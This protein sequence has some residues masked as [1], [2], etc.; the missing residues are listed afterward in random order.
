[1]VASESKKRLA[2]AIIDFLTNST[3]D[4][5]L[6]SDETESIEVATQCIADAFKV[7]PTDKAAISDAL[8]GQTLVSIYSVFEKMKGK[9]ASKPTS[10]PATSTTEGPS[11]DKKAEA[12]ALKSKGNAAIA[13]KDF[14]AAIEFYTQALNIVPNHAIYLSNRAAAYSELGQYDQAIKDAEIAVD[15]DP[16]Y[17]K[18]WS[19]LGHARYCL[20]DNKGA[21][22]AYKAGL[23]SDPT[24]VGTPQLK[25]GYEK[26]KKDVERE[27]AVQS[28]SPSQDA[29][30]DGLGGL[31]F[32][33]IMQSMQ[34]NPGMME[35]LMKGMFGGGGG[36][37]A[38][39]GSREAGEGS[40]ASGNGGGGPDFAAIAAM[41]K[42]NPSLAKMANEFLTKGGGMPDVGALMNNPMFA[43]LAQ[44]LLGGKKGPGGG[45]GSS[46]PF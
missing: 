44:N 26:S 25:A 7:D 18:A 31:D 4:G 41:V 20:G 11:E 29:A 45:S 28:K 6:A 8:G 24:G 37:G 35:G 40:G 19:R 22:E 13:Q 32:G 3:L 38:P 27:E 33:S 16:S 46:P 23:D 42:D 5:T 9:A 39:G 43:G 30:G 17:G 10:I 15:T 1:M 34:K 2:L 12:E 14:S 21:M 36:S